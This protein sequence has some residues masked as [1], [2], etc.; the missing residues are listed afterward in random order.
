MMGPC[1]AAKSPALLWISPAT[2]VCAGP[3]DLQTGGPQEEAGGTPRPVEGTHRRMLRPQPV[4][5]YRST[6]A[7][8]RSRD[9]RSRT[10]LEGSSRSRR[11]R[12]RDRRVRRGVLEQS[13]WPARNRSGGAAVL[14][15]VDGAT[16]SDQTRQP[17]DSPTNL[18][19][20]AVMLA[21]SSGPNSEAMRR[22]QSPARSTASRLL[23]NSLSS[24]NSSPSPWRR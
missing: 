10:H 18:A 14:A 4:P 21:W 13:A 17:P 8:D 9:S 12:G 20:R 22:A 3:L 24:R 7:L 23:S 19:S 11:Q 2:A 1:S 6:P 15:G 5:G 16:P